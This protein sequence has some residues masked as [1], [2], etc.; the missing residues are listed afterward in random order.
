MTDEARFNTFLIFGAPG[1]GKGTQGAVLGRLPRFFHCACGDVFRSLDTRSEIGQEFLKY[2]SE[3]LL[4]P[5]DLT[6]RL[7]KSKIDSQVDSI[8]F[9]SDIDFLVLDG[10]P[11][12]VEQAKMMEEHVKVHQVFHLSL[13]NRDELARRLRKRALKDNRLDD[14]NEAV[15]AQRLALY[16]EETRPMLEHYDRSLISEIDASLTPAEVMLE[17]LKVVTGL[18]FFKDSPKV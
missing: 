10:I 11:R 2:S 4:V 6:V 14:A 15:I 9:K 17:I 18:E 8:L 16:D 3:G 13:K 1:S 7:W 12:N 5:N